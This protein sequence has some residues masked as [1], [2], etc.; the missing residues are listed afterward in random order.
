MWLSVLNIS[1]VNI[2]LPAMA[3]S[4]DVDLTSIGWVVTAFLVTQATLL[5]IAG[6]A[7][8]LYGRRRVFLTGTVLLVVASIAC[9]LAWDAG[10][11]IAFRVVQAIGACAMAPTAYSYVGVLFSPHERGQATGVLIGAIG[12]APLVAL[13]VAGLLMAVFSWRSVFWFSPVIGALVIAGALLV[14]PRL[15]AQGER[16][17]FDIPGAVLAAAGLFGTLVAISKAEDWGY[18][19][20]ATLTAFV[21]GCVSLVGFVFWEGRAPDPLLPRDLLR[22]RSIVTSNSASGIAA[23]AL[24]GV[25]ILLPLYLA[26]VLGFGSIAI[27]LATTPIAASFLVVSPFAGRAMMRHQA[28]ALAAVGYAVGIAGAVCMAFGAGT[29]RYG[30][31]VPGLVLFAGGLALA[32]S[33]ATAVAISDVPAHRLGVASSLPNIS[34]YAGGALGTAVLGVVM[35]AAV[36]AGEERSTERAVPAVRDDIVG[37]FRAALLVAAGFLVIATLIASR[38]P[39]MRLGTPRR[40]DSP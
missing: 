39:E 34:R 11:L 31:L 30:L 2:A 25:M 6:R 1:I 18:A 35:H 14:L 29:E 12:F 37:G 4:L 16:R 13:N 8:D 27:A 40:K 22:R 38:I 24:F 21:V 33:P 23:A 10:S 5:P 17:P 28:R 32:Q 7:G 3:T 15:E 26:R 20:A 19:S 36:P 9:A